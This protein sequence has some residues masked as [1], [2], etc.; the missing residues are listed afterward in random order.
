MDAYAAAMEPALD[1][2]DDRMQSGLKGATSEWP[3]WSP[4]LTGGMTVPGHTAR[5]GDRRAA[6]EPALDGRDDARRPAPTPR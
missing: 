4:P 1:G 2:R 6:M 5:P 3:Q